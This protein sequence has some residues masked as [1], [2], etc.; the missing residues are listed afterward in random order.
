MHQSS[1]EMNIHLYCI[2]YYFKLLKRLKM[3]LSLKQHKKNYFFS[4][5][6]RSWDHGKMVHLSSSV[7]LLYVFVVTSAMTSTV[8]FNNAI[9]G[10]AVAI[11]YDLDG[12]P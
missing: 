10:N 9:R 8:S 2:N 1:S 11:R 4:L 12:S 3:L 6:E 7:T 5:E